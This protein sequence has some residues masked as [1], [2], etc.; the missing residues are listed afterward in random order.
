MTSVPTR[1]DWNPVRV[2]LL[3]LHEYSRFIERIRGIKIPLAELETCAK[4]DPC[5]PRYR[6]DAGGRKIW[7]QPDLDLYFHGALNPV[8]HAPH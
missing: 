6:K 8:Q 1:D 4:F 7:R 5:F 2:D 3:S